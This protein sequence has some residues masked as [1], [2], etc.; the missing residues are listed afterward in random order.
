VET[1][2][3]RQCVRD[4]E[5]FLA[6]WGDTAEALGWTADDLFGLHEPPER[7]HPSYSRLSRY[8]CTGL[9]WALQGQRVKAMTAT[10][11]TIGTVT[12]AILTYYRSTR[13][14]DLP[15]A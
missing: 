4:A 1:R 12:G 6:E 5:R 14:D 15:A 2:R 9:L 7:P 11:A 13:G 10:T 3:W 8:D